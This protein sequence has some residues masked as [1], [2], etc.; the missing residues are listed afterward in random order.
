MPDDPPPARE[1]S[2]GPPLDRREFLRL[3]AIA[4]GGLAFGSVVATTD[5]RVAVNPIERLMKSDP[6]D[7]PYYWG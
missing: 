1:P 5:A 6:E 7:P 2:P 3:S 4:G